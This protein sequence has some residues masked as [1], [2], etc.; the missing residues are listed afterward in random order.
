MAFLNERPDHFDSLIRVFKAPGYDKELFS[1]SYVIRR[2][3][4]EDKI[5]NVTKKP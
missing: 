5:L 2:C 3:E 4:Q 1:L